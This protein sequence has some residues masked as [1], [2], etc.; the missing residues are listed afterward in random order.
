[1]SLTYSEVVTQFQTTIFEMLMNN[2]ITDQEFAILEALTE[3]M[4]KDSDALELAINITTKDLE[5]KDVVDSILA[6]E[7]TT[8]TMI[9]W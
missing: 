5:D 2:L 6:R 4:T 7:F 8:A 9:I 1:M 3:G